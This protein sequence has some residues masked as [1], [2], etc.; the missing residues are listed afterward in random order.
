M[1]RAVVYDVNVLVDA[2][3]GER[4]DF[5]TWPVLPPT[6]TNPSADCVGIAN[7]AHDFTLWLSPHILD[8]TRR[9]L[10]EHYGVDAADADEYLDILEE[11]TIASGGQIVEPER[12]VHA[13]PDHEDNLILDLAVHAGADIVVS[14][15]TDLTSMSGWR[16]VPIL[17]P[18]VFA[19]RVDA[20]RRAQHSKP[21]GPSTT[22]RLREQAARRARRST[23]DIHVEMED[24]GPDEYL[25]LRENFARDQERLAEIVASWNRHNPAMQPRIDVWKRNLERFSEKS[26]SI[27]EISKTQPDIAHDAMIAL[28]EKMTIALDHLDPRRIAAQKKIMPAKRPPTFSADDEPLRGQHSPEL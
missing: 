4:S 26:A 1:A 21:S 19:S 20:M 5:Y 8:N 17:P 22:D 27:D 24:A 16:G 15:D 25:R 9:V 10:V 14:N 3:M 13:C 18:R 7:D 23:T 6:T 12:T 2:V 11:I 28:S